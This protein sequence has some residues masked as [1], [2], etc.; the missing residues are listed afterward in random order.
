MI[1]PDFVLSEIHRRAFGA[2]GKPTGTSPL[3]E[4]RIMSAEECAGLIVRAM[5]R[6]QRLLITSWR[7]RFGRIVRLFA[8]GLIDAVAKRAV[9]TGK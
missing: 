6:R 7:G 9:A 3:Q 5:E 4:S 2:D 8:P 1:A